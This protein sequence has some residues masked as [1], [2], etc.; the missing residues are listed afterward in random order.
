MAFHPVVL[1]AE[2]FR[3]VDE[4]GKVFYSDKKPPQKIQTTIIPINKPSA[5]NTGQVV[6]AKAIVRPQDKS[7]RILFLP[8]TMFSV[9]QNANINLRKKIGTY[10]AG[11]GCI[12]RGAMKIPDVFINHA[13]FF[14][15][16]SE[17]AY[18]IKRTI[19]SLDYRAEKTS[20]YKLISLMKETGGYSLHSEIIDMKIDSCAPKTYKKDRLT[21]AEKLPLRKFNKHRV[22]VD[23]RWRLRSDRDQ[24]LVY[25]KVVTGYFNGWN[26]DTPSQ[27]ALINAVESST[28]QLFSDPVFIN[29]ILQQTETPA[30][31]SNVQS[32][33]QP[34]GSDQD[35][36]LVSRLLA[37]GSGNPVSGISANVKQTLILKA[38]LSQ[39]M[40]DLSQV[41]MLLTQY[42]YE[43]GAWPYTMS[44]MGLSKVDYADSKSIEDLKL[45]SDGSILAELSENFGRNKFIQLSPTLSH[46]N[47]FSIN[48]WQ[49]SSNLTQNILPMNCE[50][51]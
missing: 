18:R 32:Q 17:M 11:K 15:S 43:Y 44:E 2:L 33:S 9:K 1:Q 46:S 8:D 34:K 42:Y 47:K 49:C 51:R 27:I 30:P 37:I 48:R 25:E 31:Q 28:R 4:H 7:S 10:F 26:L 24:E 35:E 21:P 40:I 22:K 14:P 20:K 29:K 45:H 39:V 38:H 41:K 19:N 6:L 12:S 13:A 16:E 50:T 3:W 5:F 23:L 36:D